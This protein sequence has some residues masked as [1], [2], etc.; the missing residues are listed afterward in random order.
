M[1]AAAAVAAA[2][3][4]G[5]SAAPTHNRHCIL[6]HVSTLYISS[7]LDIVLSLALPICLQ[8]GTKPLCRVGRTM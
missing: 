5:A 2:A 1:V 8:T 6:A 3:A 7:C 4:G